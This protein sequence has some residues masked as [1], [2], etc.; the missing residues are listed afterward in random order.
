MAPGFMKR[1]AY[2]HLTQY[3]D[4][5]IANARR[6]YAALLPAPQEPGDLLCILYLTPFTTVRVRETDNRAQNALLETTLALHTYQLEHCFFPATLGSLV[7]RYLPSFPADPFALSGP[8]R[9]K[10]QGKTYLLYSVGPDGKDDGGRPIFDATKPAP[11]ASNRAD[12]R[13]YVYDTSKGD[14]VAGVNM[15]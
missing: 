11:T 3:D 12:S 7:P 15:K 14:I 6:P 2:E 5:E 1:I 13:R 8:L 4:A 9:Y 10:V